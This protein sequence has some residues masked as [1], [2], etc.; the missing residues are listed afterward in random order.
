MADAKRAEQQ[1]LLLDA[2][3]TLWE[4]NV[5]FEQAIADF[6]SL[7]DHQQHTPA[8]IRDVLYECERATI[9]T[10][11]YGV[12]SFHRS[13]LECLE[14]LSHPPVTDRQREQVAA[15]AQSILDQQIVLLPGVADTLPVLAARHR[16]ILVTK[17]DAEEQRAKLDASGV[18]M[19]FLAVE[20]P[21]E[22]HELA[23]RR[24]IDSYA[25]DPAATWMVGNSPRSDINPALAAG[26]HAVYVHYPNTWVLEHESLDE[27]KPPQQLLQLSGFHELLEFF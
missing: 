14:Q 9:A 12:S 5:Y 10:H 24:I 26:L 20:V 6:I 21:A 25:L 18:H 23:Y 3:D 19:H 7:L 16:L 17:G 15:F 27:P 22:K 2:D 1:T 4:N 13:L 11:G 8:Q